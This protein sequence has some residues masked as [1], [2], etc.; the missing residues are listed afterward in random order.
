[1]FPRHICKKMF[2][3]RQ[4]LHVLFNFDFCLSVCL[5][6]ILQSIFG[7]FPSNQFSS[8]V[9]HGF[10][11]DDNTIFKYFQA[12]ISSMEGSRGRNLLS[13]RPKILTKYVKQG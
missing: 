4:F 13:H 2:I 8:N 11:V 6:Q 1:M 12:C 5:G 7:P 9:T 3:A 10:I